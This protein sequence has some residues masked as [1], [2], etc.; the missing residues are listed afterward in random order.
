MKKI[1]FNNGFIIALALFVE[2]KNF[3]SHICRDKDGKVYNDLRL[4]GATDHLYDLEIPKRFPVKLRKRIHRF[5]QK[6]FHFRMANFKDTKI[7]DKI[8]K[9]AEDILVQIDKQIFKLE[10]IQIHYR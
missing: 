8:F 2:H 3:T 1:Y 5:K 7:S 10:K 4:Y 6:C 9:E